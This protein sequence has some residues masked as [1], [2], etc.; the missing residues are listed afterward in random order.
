MGGVEGDE[1]DLLGIAIQDDLLF[2]GDF[3]QGVM[4][5]VVLGLLLLPAV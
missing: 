5:L 4:G 3:I 2:L 1:V